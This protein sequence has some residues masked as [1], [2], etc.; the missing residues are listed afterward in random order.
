MWF[1]ISMALMM[2]TLL[3]A[4]PASA[5]PSRSVRQTNNFVPYV[6]V[7]DSASFNAADPEKL[8]DQ[9]IKGSR[10]RGAQ[11][12][13]ILAKVQDKRL[14]KL[15]LTSGDSE[16]PCNTGLPEDMAGAA[17]DL[18]DMLAERRRELVAVIG[19]VQIMRNN[20]Q[21]VTAVIKAASTAV[22][23]M[24]PLVPS[25]NRVFQVSEE[26]TNTLAVAD[27]NFDKVGEVLSTLG[28]TNLISANQ[29]MRL[30]LR[31]GGEA[32]KIA[33]RT[34][35]AMQKYANVCPGS[36]K[37]SG[38]MLQGMAEALKGLKDISHTFG[39]QGNSVEDRLDETITDIKD[40][41]ELL[42]ELNQDL[43][44]SFGN[45]PASSADCRTGLADISKALDEVAVLVQL[46]TE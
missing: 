6:Y 11:L 35:R 46:I 27:F 25:F 21:N 23:A 45:E 43:D 39:W 36:S 24:Q 38:N 9:M 41:A 33:S 2:C 15:L 17:Q 44:L 3:T 28:A 42:R 7:P 29:T 22:Q 18:I 31:Q 30:R 34:A 37:F 10:D 12:I 16:D 1:N 13:R 19:A 14:I 40:G 32:S 4:G 5:Q 26:C 20:Q 8:V